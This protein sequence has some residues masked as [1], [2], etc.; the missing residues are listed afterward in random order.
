MQMACILMAIIV[1]GFGEIIDT[2]KPCFQSWLLTEVLKIPNNQ[3]M[4][5]R[6]RT[7]VER[8]LWLQSIT[9]WRSVTAIPFLTF[10]NYTL[11]TK[12]LIIISISLGVAWYMVHG[13]IHTFDTQNIIDVLFCFDLLPSVLKNHERY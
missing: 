3:K 1:N 10:L 4:Q 13:G 2:E 5:S 9:S 7:Y 8:K 6:T 11:R 12:M